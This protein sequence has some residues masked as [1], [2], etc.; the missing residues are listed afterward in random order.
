M[1]IL[2]RLSL[3]IVIFSIISILACKAN[4]ALDSTIEM[5]DQTKEM[6]GEIK[7]TNGQ[8]GGMD[9]SLNKTNDSMD[10]MTVI[11]KELLQSMKEM[12]ELGDKAKDLEKSL[13]L[14]QTVRL[15]HDHPANAI[16]GA[17]KLTKA[18]TVE[19]ILSIVRLQMKRIDGYGAASEDGKKMALTAEQKESLAYSLNAIGYKMPPEK[20]R[21]MI[22]EHIMKQSPLVKYA[23]T[24]LAYR[25]QT[26]SLIIL[27]ELFG[28]MGDNVPEEKK[29]TTNFPLLEE[30][31]QKALHYIEIVDLGMSE[32][33]KHN[34]TE[35]YKF[36]L[37]ETVKG[38]S[39]AQ[40][41]ETVKFALEK[42]LEC[43]YV[44]SAEG[45]ERLSDFINWV[46]PYF[47][48]HSVDLPNKQCP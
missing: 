37:V 25:A 12:L 30:S 24:L 16:A 23:L 5:K 33:I 46:H 35:K 17:T 13:A 40:V 44:S 20:V 21:E 41:L 22:E 9:K 3:T 32:K 2:R 4:K 39:P 48:K 11:M 19:E 18:A 42:R 15:D 43:E 29:V 10:G 6:L 31:T 45:E 8:M 47:E 14:E 28:Q 38:I 34:A 36:S 7:K 1:R 26:L 27:S